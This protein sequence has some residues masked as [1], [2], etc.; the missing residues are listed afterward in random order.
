[1]AEQTVLSAGMGGIPNWI[2]VIVGEDGMKA[3]LLLR[4]NAYVK[5]H[6]VDEV[7]QI[8]RKSGIQMGIR[9]GIIKEILDK[10]MFDKHYLVAQGVMPRH[11]KNGYFEYF[12]NTKA[13]TGIPKILDDGRV[14]YSQI[15]ELVKGEQKLALYHKADK[16]EDGYTVT[17]EIKPAVK[18]EELEP[19]NLTGVR[20]EGDSY[21]AAF[22]GRVILKGTSLEV[23][24]ALVVEGSVNNTYGN[25][26]F[27]GDVFVKGDIAAGMMVE[28]TGS[29]I[30]D[31]T[32]EAAKVR[33]RKDIII[34]YGVH[35]EGEAVLSADGEIACNFLEGAK[36]I[37]KEKIMSG[38]IINSVVHTDSYVDVTQAKGIIMGGRVCGMLGVS[39]NV[40]GHRSGMETL[41]FAG[42]SPDDTKEI[43]KIRKS[44]KSC[45]MYD[46]KMGMD[47][48]ALEAE[49]SQ[50]KNA[51]KSYELQGKLKELKEEKKQL[52]L[53]IEKNNWNLEQLLKKI[54]FAKE[55]NVVVN[56]M[57]YPGTV[58]TI[59]TVEAEKLS[60]IAGAKFVREG[61]NIMVEP[62]TKDA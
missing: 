18:G 25:V 13:Q 39:A 49:I 44:L 4:S 9:D 41:I 32:I 12:F 30:V 16:G 48:K 57:L 55:A 62:F 51:T 20:R 59:G 6:T 40:I 36:V 38:S 37:S 58:I 34:G 54:E 46:Q 35:G 26:N 28:A 24:P 17:G 45:M 23:D 10:K 14:D 3:A 21:F 52:T 27:K 22:D 33:A 47:E 8:L 29:I 5:E 60:G 43:N 11:G 1:M 42:A 61:V 2:E 15:I 56:Q 19:L 7:K 31:G 53:N 50:T